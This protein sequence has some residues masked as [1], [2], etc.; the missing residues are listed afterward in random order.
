[1]STLTLLYEVA[2]LRTDAKVA[3]L[4]FIGVASNWALGYTCPRPLPA[5][6]IF[7]A[8]FLVAQSLEQ[9]TL[10]GSLSAI[11]LKTY[12]IVDDRRSHTQKELK[13]F[14][15]LA[16]APSDPDGAGDL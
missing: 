5:T 15:F 14:S 3:A 6:I 8:H 12:E 9:Q 11:A 2:P 1:M 4:E 13:S 7:P 16:A 10:C